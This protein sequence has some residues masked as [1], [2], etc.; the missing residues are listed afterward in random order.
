MTEDNAAE[1]TK[2]EADAESC[3]GGQ[4]THCRANLREKFAVKNQRG[5][6]AVE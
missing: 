6:N 2:Q 1:G 4:R 5:G 3:K